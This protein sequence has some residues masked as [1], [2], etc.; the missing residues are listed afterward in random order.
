M[1]QLLLIM[2]TRPYLEVPHLCILHSRTHLVQYDLFPWL[3]NYD[4]PLW[5]DCRL[6]TFSNGEISSDTHLRSYGDSVQMG[7]PWN[8][9]GW[10]WG[11]FN[12]CIPTWWLDMIWC[13]SYNLWLGHGIPV[14]IS[15]LQA[16]S[17]QCRS[18]GNKPWMKFSGIFKYQI[19]NLRILMEWTIP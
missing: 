10:I 5:L 14:K 4:I 11:H 13:Q 19:S 3:A 15:L 12:A 6:L 8:S 17:T 16:L 1:K 2:H 18:I 7:M 9:I